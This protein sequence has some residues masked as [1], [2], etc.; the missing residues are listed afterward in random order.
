M[1]TLGAALSDHQASFDRLSQANLVC[2]NASTFAKTAKRKDYRINLMGVGINP[3]LALRS[4]VALPLV[5]T[6]DPDELLSKNPLVEGTHID[7]RSF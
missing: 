5:R 6:A 7:Y 1:R 4:R 3:S 2:K